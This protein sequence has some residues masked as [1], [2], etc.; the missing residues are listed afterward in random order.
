MT[1]AIYAAS[2]QIPGKGWYLFGGNSL[3]TSQRLVNVSS[4]WVAGPAVQTIWI[5][6][7]CAI[8]V[9]NKNNEIILFK[10]FSSL[11]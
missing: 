1:R 8:Q 7:Q 10:E 3:S 4:N 11:Y 9:M 5:N 6:G 2:I